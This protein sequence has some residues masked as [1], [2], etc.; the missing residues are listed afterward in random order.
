[1]FTP[2]RLKKFHSPE[3][4]RSLAT[5]EKTL[6]SPSTR[7]NDACLRRRKSKELDELLALEAWTPYEELKFVKRL[8]EG[9]SARVDLCTYTSTST[10]KAVAEFHVAL[11]VMKTTAGATD[12][13]EAPED[14]EPDES[15]STFQR[16]VLLLRRLR[17][18]N[19]VACYGCVRRQPP[20]RGAA[21]AAE[22]MFLQEYCDGGTLLD[23]VQKP[24]SYSA[25]DALRWVVDICRGMAYLHGTGHT[26]VRVAHRDLKLEN[27]LL[28]NGSHG[29]AKVRRNA[30][31]DCSSAR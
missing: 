28:K 23:R 26:G 1:M 19:V 12:H 17:H 25:H 22:L 13:F 24:R 6:N 30:S 9:A 2:F 16:E 20:I 27:I 4:R 7:V 11:K 8:G 21:A 15:V 18:R 31:T 10:T 29:T 5:L 14:F 3:S